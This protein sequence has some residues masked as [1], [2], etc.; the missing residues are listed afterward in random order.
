MVPIWWV[1]NSGKR[2]VRAQYKHRRL[3]EETKL[4]YQKDIPSDLFFLSSPVSHRTREHD[5][6]LTMIC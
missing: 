3:C 1:P 6:L 4:M 5:E 2:S